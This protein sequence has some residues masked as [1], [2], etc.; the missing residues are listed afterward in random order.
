[1]IVPLLSKH[2]WPFLRSGS[3]TLLNR[4]RSEPL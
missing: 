3:V 4:E 2:F 1:M